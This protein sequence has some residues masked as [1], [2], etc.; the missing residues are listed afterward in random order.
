VNAE[1]IVKY[2]TANVDNGVG[3]LNEKGRT[4]EWKADGNYGYYVKDYVDSDG[5]GFIDTETDRFVGGCP[6]VHNIC[7]SG[8]KD[9]TMIYTT[10]KDQYGN[11]HE[12]FIYD[13]TKKKFVD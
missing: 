8:E 6:G 4:C 7:P 3:T 12:P 11:F 2:I 9:V 10:W 13:P 5:D 1:D